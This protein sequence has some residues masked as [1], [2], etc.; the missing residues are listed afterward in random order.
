M[1]YRQLLGTPRAPPKTGTTPLSHMHSTIHH[2]QY[3]LFGS[4]WVINSTT[5][6][7]CC[8]IFILIRVLLYR[9]VCTSSTTQEI[10]CKNQSEE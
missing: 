9:G 7:F 6:I 2:I 1:K 5:P 3:D 4:S 8:F 10:G